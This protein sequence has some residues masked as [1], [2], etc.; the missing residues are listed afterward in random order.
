MMNFFRIHPDTAGKEAMIHAS[1]CLHLRLVHDY[2]QEPATF[3]FE[4]VVGLSEQ[5]LN[6]LSDLLVGCDENMLS[7]IPRGFKECC[8]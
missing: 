6:E 4:S 1:L 2:P 8:I 3:S 7:L 5:T